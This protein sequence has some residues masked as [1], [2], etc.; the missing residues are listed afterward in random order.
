MW[1][2]FVTFYWSSLFVEYF[3]VY[4][5]FFINIS[6]LSELKKLSMIIIPIIIGITLLRFKTSQL[7]VFAYFKVFKMI[8]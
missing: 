4:H 6:G 8:F 1:D 2:L 3:H 5:F 7:N